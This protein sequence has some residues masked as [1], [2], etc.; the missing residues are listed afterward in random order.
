MFNWGIKKRLVERTPFRLE[1]VTVINLEREMPRAMRFQTDEDEQ[2]LLDAANPHLR[3]LITAMLDTACRPGELLSLQ[4]KDVNLKRK[5]IT[6]R[7]EKSKTRTGRI[8]PVS[9]RLAAT[10]DVRK[11]ES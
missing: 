5:E 4:W 10:L 3:A 6:V 8:V 1:G 11:L 7:A 9:T 2:K